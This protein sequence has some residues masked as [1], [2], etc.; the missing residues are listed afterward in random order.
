M[1]PLKLMVCVIVATGSVGCATLTKR[2]TV[3]IP[4]RRPA[5]GCVDVR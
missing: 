3:R 4:I 1:A 2:D 5:G